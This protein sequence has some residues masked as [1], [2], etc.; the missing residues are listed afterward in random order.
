LAD[1]VLMA[2][3]IGL[4]PEITGTLALGSRAFAHQH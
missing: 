4:L 2:G 3:K 1:L